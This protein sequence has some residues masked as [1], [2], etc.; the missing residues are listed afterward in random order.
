MPDIRNRMLDII[1]FYMQNPNWDQMSRE[2]VQAAEEECKKAYDA[3]AA[4]AKSRLV[5][6]P[7]KDGE[8]YE[9]WSER[10]AD[11][12][13]DKLRELEIEFERRSYIAELDYK[14]MKC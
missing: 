2:L 14:E 4:E 11:A 6:E 8:T 9:E 5:E 13:H 3:G 12:F 1:N 7:R 10:N